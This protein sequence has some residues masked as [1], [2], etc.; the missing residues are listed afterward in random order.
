MLNIDDHPYFSHFAFLTETDFDAIT[1]T[2]LLLY[3]TD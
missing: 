1:I 3:F 2:S